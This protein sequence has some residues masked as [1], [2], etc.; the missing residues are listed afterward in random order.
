M[1]MYLFLDTFSY[2]FR[3]VERVHYVINSSTEKAKY[4]YKSFVID[5]I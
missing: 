5:E 1:S 2:C 3:D 4:A